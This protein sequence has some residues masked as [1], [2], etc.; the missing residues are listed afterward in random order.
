MSTHVLRAL[1]L[2][3]LQIELIKVYRDGLLSNYHSDYSWHN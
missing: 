3:L 1:V 2:V